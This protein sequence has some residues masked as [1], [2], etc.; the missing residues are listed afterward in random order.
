MNKIEFA[1]DPP[2]DCPE[3][4]EWSGDPNIALKD[5]HGLVSCRK[6]QNNSGRFNRGNL[7]RDKIENKWDYILKIADNSIKINLNLKNE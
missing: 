7:Q 1:L 3:F 2:I 5:K 6:I 4:G